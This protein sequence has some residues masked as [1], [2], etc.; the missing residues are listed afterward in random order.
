MT[1]EDRLQEQWVISL[2]F[3]TNLFSTITE[4]QR[5]MSQLLLLANQRKEKWQLR[6]YIFFSSFNWWFGGTEPLRLSHLVSHHI[7]HY[8]L[9]M[10]AN[11]LEGYSAASPHNSVL[12]CI[13]QREVGGFKCR[14]G[15]SH[16]LHVGGK[17]NRNKLLFHAPGDL[18]CAETWQHFIHEDLRLLPRR[19]LSFVE[20][21]NVDPVRPFTVSLSHV[22]HIMFPW[23]S[24]SERGAA[25]RPFRHKGYVRHGWVRWEVYMRYCSVSWPL[26]LLPCRHDWGGGGRF[27]WVYGGEAQQAEWLWVV[28]FVNMELKQPCVWKKTDPGGKV[29]CLTGFP[30]LAAANTC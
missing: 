13:W 8:I 12:K 25:G 6:K 4:K 2:V 17:T 29:C 24:A 10:S 7:G 9:D 14:M 21:R 16:R 22:R 20:Q 11:V 1:N 27:G 23:K 30:S 26:G 5:T 28:W 15:L 18:W 19:R 3:W